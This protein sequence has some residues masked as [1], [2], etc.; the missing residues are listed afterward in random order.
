[1][2]NKNKNI[3]NNIIIVADEKDVIGIKK[4]HDYFCQILLHD[5]H[6]L[7]FLIILKFKSTTSHLK[8]ENY[9]YIISY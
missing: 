8:T 2:K 1:M 7:F 3:I 6:I 5:L 9:F 4:H